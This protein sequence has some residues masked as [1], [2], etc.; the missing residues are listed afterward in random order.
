MPIYPAHVVPRNITLPLFLKITLIVRAFSSGKSQSIVLICIGC[1]G[2][3]TTTDV[4]AA[5]ASYA[6]CK[7]S[8]FPALISVCSAIPRI[9]SLYNAVPVLQAT[10]KSGTSVD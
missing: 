7:S 10:V 1:R 8:T 3:F 2:P 6:S 4:Q 5:N 9:S